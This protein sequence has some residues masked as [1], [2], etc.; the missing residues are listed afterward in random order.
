VSLTPKGFIGSAVSRTVSLMLRPWMSLAFLVPLVACGASDKPVAHPGLAMFG[1]ACTESGTCP[2][3]LECMRNAGYGGETGSCEKRC[4]YDAD[5][6]VG[7]TC[8]MSPGAPAP[9]CRPKG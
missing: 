1:N 8:K 3:D 4:N 2:H 7:A 6:G 5:C 9:V